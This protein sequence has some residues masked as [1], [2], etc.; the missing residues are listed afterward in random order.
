MSRVEKGGRSFRPVLKG[1]RKPPPQ[2]STP[3]NVSQPSSSNPI[4][5]PTTH[6]TSTLPAP[7][8]ATPKSSCPSTQIDVPSSTPLETASSSSSPPVASQNGPPSNENSTGPSEVIPPNDTPPITN[9]SSS[10][11]VPPHNALRSIENI[12]TSQGSPPTNRMIRASSVM[13][14]ISTTS[15]H[16]GLTAAEKMKLK[17]Q[18]AKAARAEH[19]LRNPTPPPS[20]RSSVA[21]RS[22]VPPEPSILMSTATNPKPVAATRTQNS[23]LSASAEPTMIGTDGLSR[24]VEAISHFVEDSSRLDDIPVPSQPYASTLNISTAETAKKNATKQTST[25]KPPKKAPTV[26]KPRKK[27]VPNPNPTENA[28]AD[29]EDISPRLKRK[30]HLSALRA[31]KAKGKGKGRKS[32]TPDLMVTPLDN[33]AHPENDPETTK[34]FNDS[35]GSED[36]GDNYEES[37]DDESQ[38]ENNEKVKPKPKKRS[39]SKS[40][41]K[42]QP[43]KKKAKKNDPD[44]DDDEASDTP[45]DPSKVKMDFL[46]APQLSKGRGCETLQNRMKLVIERRDREKMERMAKREEEKRKRRTPAP[47]RETT[48]VE[49]DEEAEEGDEVQEED[50]DEETEVA[51][52][53]AQ[54]KKSLAEAYGLEDLDSDD[55]MDNFEEVTFDEFQTTS[56]KTKSNPK[57]PVPQV[58]PDIEEEEE[59]VVEEDYVPEPTQY[60]PQLRVVDG[61]IVLDQDSLQVE[62]QDQNDRLDE[63]E[64]VEEHDSTRLVNSLTWSKK[65]RGER[66]S[67]EETALFFDAVRL[68]GSDFEMITQLFPG[69][70]RKQIRLKWIKEEKKAPQIMTDMMM[71]RQPSSRASVTPSV[72]EEEIE[73]EEDTEIIRLESLNTFEEYAKWV[74]I[75][76]TGPIPE[77][78]MDKWREKE[79]LKDLEMRKANEMGSKKAGDDEE[80]DEE[81]E[82]PIEEEVDTS[83]WGQ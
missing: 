40:K 63:M 82:E 52:T 10:Q 11:T 20:R 66:W 7:T 27:A 54:A 76:C 69:R 4:S 77:D 79:R 58:L 29:E 9:K 39:A 70:N 78:P 1:V 56:K 41:S 31:A 61:Q 24:D 83:H 62:R 3:S 8:K 57:A 80:E 68:F 22:S 36:D 14:N 43:K 5:T 33:T 12:S 25:M 73:E 16:S 13:S 74:G 60:A 67:A 6:I 47:R 34:L 72:P 26:K 59:E 53:A 35:S 38:S 64:I 45:I 18:A 65:I 46:C 17:A 81:E 51:N 75:D 30:R 42:P 50:E 55:D 15:S 49:E 32:A 48:V 28:D 21:P 44:E 19:K 23:S 71:G 2:A 37:D